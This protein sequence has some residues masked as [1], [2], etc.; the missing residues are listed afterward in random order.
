MVQD[1]HPVGHLFAMQ[2]NRMDIRTPEGEIIRCMRSTGADRS[3]AAPG[4]APGGQWNHLLQGQLCSWSGSSSGGNSRS[5]TRRAFFDG[6]GRFA[7]GSESSW[8]A[9]S[10]NS[11]GDDLGAV[12]A[13]HE[14]GGP[15][16]TYE[17]TAASPDA[18]IRVQW[19]AGEADVACVH[20]VSGVRITASKHGEMLFGTGGCE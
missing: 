11:V 9:T 18:P 7:T 16:G 8:S 5:T 12:S 2:N 20:H 15:G 17:V 14:G 19:S 1:G 13:Y 6:R 3:A 10:R 4:T